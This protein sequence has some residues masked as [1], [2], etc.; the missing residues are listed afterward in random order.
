MQDDAEKMSRGRS[1]NRSSLVL[2]VMAGAG[3]AGAGAAL[4]ASQFAESRQPPQPVVE[5]LLSTSQT[6]LGEPISYPTLP[7]KVVAAIVTLPP[8]ASTGWHRHGVP[9]FG[10]VLSGEL[11]VDY[12]AR[13]VR[14]YRAGDSFMEAMDAA[15]NGRNSGEGDVRILAVY[16]AGEGLALSHEAEAP[17]K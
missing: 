5:T 14:V 16:M 12:G 7:A 13:R 17:L 4:L 1:A 2:G 10:Y 11:T 8:G 9:L 6:I 15:H 3:L